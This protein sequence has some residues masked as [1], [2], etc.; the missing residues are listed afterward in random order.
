MRNGF[1]I[2]AMAVFTD[3]VRQRVLVVVLA[4]LAIAPAYGQQQAAEPEA[5]VS[6]K[7]PLAEEVQR[8]RVANKQPS[9]ASLEVW[10]RRV[11]DLILNILG[12]QKDAFDA[13]DQII[14]I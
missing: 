7:A 11:D 1:L 3:R 5:E 4:A 13:D 2:P 6:A 12:L 8:A 10:D 14:L 9:L